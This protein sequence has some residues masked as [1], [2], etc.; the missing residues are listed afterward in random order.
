MRHA[1]LLRTPSKQAHGAIVE[2]SKPGC[3]NDTLDED[4]HI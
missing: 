1:V 2:T 4:T 3:V